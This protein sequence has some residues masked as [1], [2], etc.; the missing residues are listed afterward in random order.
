M[1]YVSGQD[2]SDCGKAGG[3]TQSQIFACIQKTLR[4]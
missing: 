1:T 4:E 3:N 2:P